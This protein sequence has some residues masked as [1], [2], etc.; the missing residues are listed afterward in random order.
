[1]SDEEMLDEIF[2]YLVEFFKDEPKKALLWMFTPNPN[3]G[4]ISPYKMYHYRR[5][6]KLWEFVRSC[7]LEN[8]NE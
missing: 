8:P 7:R 6:K 5:L 1:M 2:E 4:N 3:L